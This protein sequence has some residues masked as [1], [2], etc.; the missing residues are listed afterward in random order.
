M[1][2][3]TKAAIQEKLADALERDFPAS[4]RREARLPSLP[5]KAHAIIGMRRAGKTFFL[6]QC[7]QDELTRGVAR[8]RLVYFNLEDERLGS[9][10]AEDLSLIVET[11]YRR[12]PTFRRREEVVFCFDGIQLVPGWERFVRRIMDSEK[13]RV[14]L[15][16]SSAGMLSREVATSMRGRAMET[17]ITPFSF[18]E[19]LSYRNLKP[20][21]G[22]ETPS[23]RHRSV[24]Q[25]AF[26][27]Y[28]RRGGF[29]E[30]Q[31][32][33]REE[34]RTRL[35]QGYVD[36][37]LFRDVAER[38]SV[39]NLSALRLMVRQ[40]LRNPATPL[41]VSK[42]SRDFHSQGIAA[43]KETLLSFMTYLEDA[44]LVFA[45]PVFARSERRRQ[46]NPRK[47]YLADHGLAAAF[48][49][50]ATLDRGHLLE[51]I[52]ACELARCSRDLAYYKPPGGLEVD[53]ISRGF[54]G[55]E[56]LIQVAAD[57]SD[58]RTW[59]REVAAL[60]EAKAAR[61]QAELLLLCEEVP[62]RGM[63]IPEGI[64]VEPVWRW[65]LGGR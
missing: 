22:G 27:D 48:S 21:A 36:A 18:R 2:D 52:V 13:T 43:S 55:R 40:L 28:V 14:F 39:Q 20:P 41:S 26:D 65:L 59:Q 8:E 6:F 60:Q 10:G 15:S 17:V 32:A 34:D 50:T 7:L 16:G 24:L 51:N 42:I 11:Y 62:D 44:F 47:L 37:V 64:H 45:L 3:Q 12:F 19:F 49:P 57:V 35:L 46:V 23:A 29:P 38:H 61:P 30:A 56:R 9:M 1:E 63:E 5:G 53:F 58:P 31:A 25:A 33:E 4:T 54:D